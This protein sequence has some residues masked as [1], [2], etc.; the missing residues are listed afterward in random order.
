[1][2]SSLLLTI[3]ESHGFRALLAAIVCDNRCRSLSLGMDCGTCRAAT[4]S[5]PEWMLAADCGLRILKSAK[6]R[7]HAGNQC[8]GSTL[9]ETRGS[10]YHAVCV[11]S[12]SLAFWLRLPFSGSRRC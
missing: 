8:F 9:R 4:G 5:P 1:M 2:S 6:L 10:A 7:V 11:L 3:T 12:T